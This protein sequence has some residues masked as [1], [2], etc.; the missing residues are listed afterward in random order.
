MN[1]Q[2][3][4]WNFDAVPI[5]TGYI[6]SVRPLLLPYGPDGEG[7]YYRQGAVILCRTFHTTTESRSEVQPCVTRSGSVITWD[8][9][10]DNRRVLID[11]LRAEISAD[12]NLA[13]V[14][15]VAAAYDRWATDCFQ[16]LIGDWALS[17]WDQRNREVI[18][19][20]D[21]A[22]TRS[23]YYSVDDGQVAWCS[24]L[25]PLIASSACRLELDEEYIAGWL[26]LFPAVDLTPYVGVHAVPPSCFVRIG[27]GKSEIRRYWDFNNAKQIRYRKDA[28][29]EEHFRAVFGESI[30]RRLRAD[31]PV[32]A[33]LSGG[34]DSSSIVCVA[35]TL[36]EQGLAEAPRLDTVSYFND[37]EPNWDERSYFT[38]VEERRGRTGCHIDADAQE[39]LLWQGNDECFRPTPGSGGSA[40]EASRQLAVQ[41][42]RQGNRVVLSGIGGDE[43][44]GGV[45]T[46]L[47]ELADLLATVQLRALAC[48]LQSWAVHNRRPWFH[49]LY[50]TIQAFLPS[51]R[52]RSPE[53]VHQA[54]W[55]CSSFVRRNQRALKGYP[56]RLSLMGPL[57]SFRENMN[58]LNVLRRQLGCQGLSRYPLYEKRYPFLDRDL[59]KFLY[60]V[61]REQLIRPGQRRSL[62]RRALVGIVPDEI[63]N[64]RRKAYVTRLPSAL[65]SDE[66]SKLTDLDRD[67]ISAGLGFVDQ[68]EFVGMVRKASGGLEA[69][70]IPLMR[71]MVLEGWLQGL[72]RHAVIQRNEGTRCAYVN[73]VA[74]PFSN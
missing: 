61:P 44:T 29:Y 36:L 11:E 72:Q 25:D 8:G 62:M 10:L 6:E 32:L 21:F 40:T 23:L 46:P 54:S 43:V 2:F 50:E 33:E 64:R 35:D 74:R 48:Q 41:M 31:A 3:G 19:A 24:I 7:A 65:L 42:A 38:K 56:S 73:G 67:L 28:E 15:I 63:L 69:P 45:P 70:I 13:D 60:A 55:L 30:R 53:Q 49:L 66:I 4:R 51:V 5:D 52:T 26:G 47:P 22:G 71:T 39:S 17:V 57:P 34:M 20:K 14:S 12:P 16:R 18:L 1:I 9:R 68:D 27:Q 37:S 59:L 58:T